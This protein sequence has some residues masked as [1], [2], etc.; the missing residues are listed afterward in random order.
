M[1]IKNG[2]AYEVNGSVYFD[3]LKY[4]ESKEYGVLSGRKIE[5]ACKY[6]L[7]Y[8]KYMVEQIDDAQYGPG[9]KNR[10]KEGIRRSILKNLHK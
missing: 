6:D 2:F 3:V 5:D 1:I 4:N 8:V 7:R 10:L 9:L